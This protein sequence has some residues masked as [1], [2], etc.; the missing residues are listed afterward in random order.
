MTKNLLEGKIQS[1][2]IRLA[3]PLLLGNILQQLYNA[4]DSIIIG[5]FVSSTAFAAVG[6]AGTVM[7]LFVFVI[8]GVCVG[9]A[10]LFAQLYGAQ[11][12]DGYRRETFLALSFGSGFTLALTVLALLGLP[13]ILRLIQTPGEVA[14][15]VSVYLRIIFGGFL[16]TYWYNLCAA[17]LRSVGNTRTSLLFLAVS[18]IINTGLDILFVAVFSL[19]VAG[20][21]AATVIAQLVSVICSAVYI[22]SKL[23]FA[24]FRRR[25]MT[26]DR[27][28]LAQTARFGLVSALHQSSLY[29]GKLLVQGAVNSM[30]TAC[31][32]AFTAATRIEGFA[33]SFGDSGAEALSVFVAQNTGA[34]QKERAKK[35][36]FTGMRMMVILC[37]CVCA[38]MFFCAP[39]LVR[40]FIGTNGQEEL[41]QGTFYLRMIS[42]FYLFCFLGASFVGYFR[43]TGRVN[44]PVLGTTLHI[45]IRVILSYLL[46]G[47]LRLGAVAIAT[48][49]GWIA[50]AG[51][52]TLF[53]LHFRRRQDFRG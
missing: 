17:M 32:S 30:G 10:I 16:A 37:L 45:S 23:P 39:Q 49:I 11:D 25:D 22:R 33:N 2:L 48:G 53:F 50:V 35:G 44:L 27:A 43:G 52:H 4:V 51:L 42:C 14:G 6:V 29:I 28:L 5:R 40:F 41:V 20:A 8:S 21:A 12:L 18:V 15:E 24:M 3:L 13:W 9:V 7:N 46:I 19:G 1:Q 47:R 31:I 34:G 38:V 36:L 26:V